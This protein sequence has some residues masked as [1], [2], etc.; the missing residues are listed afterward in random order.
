MDE[1][2]DEI[3]IPVRTTLVSDEE[4]QKLSWH[5]KLA[6]GAGKYQPCKKKRILGISPVEGK[7]NF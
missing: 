5:A 3:D 6:F 7:I 4:Q 1:T 2:G